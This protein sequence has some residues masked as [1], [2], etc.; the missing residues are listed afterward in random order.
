M[1]L[2][3]YNLFHTLRIIIKSKKILNNTLLTPYIISDNWKQYLKWNFPDYMKILS[4][5]STSR[6]TTNSGGIN[7]SQSHE[8][9]WSTTSTSRSANIIE[10]TLLQMLLTV[11]YNGIGSCDSY[12]NILGNT[13]SI[14]NQRKSETNTGKKSISL[15]FTKISMTIFFWVLNRNWIKL[16]HQGFYVK[17]R[18]CSSDFS[19]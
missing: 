5:T 9:F 1:K 6:A 17:I 18:N 3:Q 10:S 2:Y 12:S 11:P 8:F 4:S 7:I 16:F 19:T 13:N 14:S 15:L